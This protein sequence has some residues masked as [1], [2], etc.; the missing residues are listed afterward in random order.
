MLNQRRRAVLSALV[1]EYIASAHPV[2]S[3]VLVERYGLRV[4]PA[5]VRHDLAVLEETGYVYQP[6]ISAGRVPTDGG[7]RAY[8]DAISDHGSDAATEQPEAAAIRRFFGE[9]EMEMSDVMRET[10]ALLSRMTAYMSVVVSPAVRRARIKRL[11]LVSLGP[12][13]VL[14]VVITDRGQVAKR[15]VEL[16]APITESELTDVERFLAGALD[17]LGT[18][19]AEAVHRELLQAPTAFRQIA[20]AL[21]AEVVACMVEAEDERFVH[22]G[23]AGL[24]GLPEFADP[25]SARPLLELVEE[26][27]VLVHALAELAGEGETVVRIGRENTISGLSNASIVATSFG[28]ADAA[29]VVCLIGPTRMDYNRAIGVTRCVADALSENL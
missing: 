12:R 21:I 25:R 14:L 20:A 16:S 13:Q 7:Y 10:A 24:L 17:A 15:F 9:R 5:T 8:V 27:L 1:S 23:A 26:G 4:S 2:A 28:P 3:R 11:S 6:H 18:A 29:G 19:E 22:G